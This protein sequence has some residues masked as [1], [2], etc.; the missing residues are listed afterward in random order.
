MAGSD[1]RESSARP[2]RQARS[3]ATLDRLLDATEALLAEKPFD[4]ASV[5]EIVHRAGTSVGAFYG[6]FPDK[7]SLLDCFDERFF[8]LAR[9]SCAEFFDSD[10]WRRATLEDSVAQLVSL[11]VCNHRRHRGTLRALALRAREQSQSHFRERAALHNRYVLAKIKDHLLSRSER[12]VH[13]DPPRA[14]ELAFLF[15]VSSVREAVLFDD[16]AGL[17]APGDDELTAELTRSFLAYLVAGEPRADS[18][19]RSMVK[20]RRPVPSPERP[21]APNKNH[22]VDPHSGR[23]GKLR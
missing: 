2:P 8:A 13:P 18:P 16:V 7:D 6:R 3:R 15:T 4:A 22:P 20:R 19:S 11:L 14:V 1:H 9:Q 23:S 21:S 5:A 17:P 12:I 10:E